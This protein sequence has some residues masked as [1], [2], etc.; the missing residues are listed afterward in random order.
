MFHSGPYWA[1]D[2]DFEAGRRTFE[3]TVRL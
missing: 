1:N 3:H 2:V